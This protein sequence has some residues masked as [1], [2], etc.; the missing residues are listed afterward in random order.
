MSPY[1]GKFPVG[2]T[3]TVKGAGMPAGTVAVSGETATLKLFTTATAG[4]GAGV[5]GGRRTE[6][7]D[8]PAIAHGT[9][10]GRRGRQ[11]GSQHHGDGR[12]RSTVQGSDRAGHGA[13]G[14]RRGT[15]R[16]AGNTVGGDESGVGRYDV[17]K[18]DA[19]GQ[20]PI[21]G[22][23]VGEG[24]VVAHADRIRAPPSR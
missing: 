14:H 24:N 3:V 20:V 19:G 15:T 8:F 9:R 4:G 5:T 18:D 13:I 16:L 21:V 6:N 12:D 11:R 17:G 7:T 10:L 23:L 22:D 2:V 1:S